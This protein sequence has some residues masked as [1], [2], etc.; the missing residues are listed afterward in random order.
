[1]YISAGCII[2]QTV[3]SLLALLIN[4]HIMINQRIERSL[5]LNHAIDYVAES[6]GHQKCN[7]KNVIGKA[8]E[9]Q[10]N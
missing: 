6:L 4:Y 1:M 3:P 7:F 2:D 8:C 10:A 5:E 9:L